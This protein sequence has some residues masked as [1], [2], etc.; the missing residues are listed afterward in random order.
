MPEQH[1]LDQHLLLDS[2][3]DEG[4]IGGSNLAGDNLR[5]SKKRNSTDFNDETFLILDAKESLTVSVT[6]FIFEMKY[7][8]IIPIVGEQ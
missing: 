6:T 8:S 3:L 4:E 1:N 7:S 5:K 2:M